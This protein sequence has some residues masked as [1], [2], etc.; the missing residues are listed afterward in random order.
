MKRTY[1]TFFSLVSCAI[2][3]FSVSCSKEEKAVLSGNP[4]AP[5]IQPHGSIEITKENRKETTTFKWTKADFGYSAAVTYK[6]LG[7][8]GAYGQTDVIGVSQVDS[9][10]IELDVLNNQLL[11]MG[12]TAGIQNQIMLSVQA[13]VTSD[14]AY[15]SVMSDM[16]IIYVNPYVSC[17]QALHLVGTMFDDVANYPGNDY[18][19]IAN[20]KYVMFRDSNLAVN[21]YTAFFRDSSEFQI[22]MNDGLNNWAK[23]TY[24]AYDN[25]PGNLVLGGSYANIK[26]WNTAGYYTFTA[27]IKNMKYT[28]LPYSTDGK[29]IYTEMFI[30]GS[31]NSWS[32]QA[33]TQS[34]YD[35]HIWII[36]NVMLD[37]GD[38]VKFSLDPNGTSIYSAKNFP[39]GRVVQGGDAVISDERGNY[40]IKFNDLTGHYVFYK[41]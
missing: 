13:S 35:S 14:T 9:L 28:F 7:K 19:N 10:T 39:Y 5:S 1:K 21:T 25:S 31:Y 27:D 6:L 2:I 26:L 22:A 40:F 16:K 11:A 36:D 12:A 29:P 8:V 37:E 4:K 32:Y 24:G 38:E 23:A 18:W 3:F 20:Y 15:P 34:H 17:P 30:G 41:K 33:M